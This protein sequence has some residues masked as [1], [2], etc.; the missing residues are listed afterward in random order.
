MDT[1]FNDISRSVSTHQRC[2]KKLCGMMKNDEAMVG[3]FLLAIDQ[4]LLYSSSN[5]YLD[6]LMKFIVRVMSNSD[7]EEG[8][9]EEILK[10]VCGRSGCVD[11]T[12]RLR[13]CKILA[14]S[15]S[16]SDI[17]NCPIELS[18]EMCDLVVT[19]FLPRLR[20]RFQGVRSEAVGVLGRFQQEE[21]DEIT[22]ELIRMLEQET[23]KDM[24]KLCVENVMLTPRTIT[25]IVNRLRDVSWEV[26]LSVLSTLFSKVHVTALS[27]SHLMQVT[28]IISFLT[29]YWGDFI[30]N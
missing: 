18:E 1:L 29:T 3:Q 4:I 27:P 25:P 10:H 30:E 12:V 20:D 21:E 2:S 7:L 22:K 5:A 6:R 14:N 19:S 16:A 13:C 11:K 26:R 8:N 15:F 17:K 24:R 28:K 9:F 23:S